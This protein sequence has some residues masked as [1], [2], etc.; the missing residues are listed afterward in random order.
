MSKDS[1]RRSDKAPTTSTKNESGK[2]SMAFSKSDGTWKRV[3]THG[4]GAHGHGHGHG[5][6]VPKSGLKTHRPV[7]AQSV[8]EAVKDLVKKRALRDLADLDYRRKLKLTIEVGIPQNMVAA[9][10]HVA[11]PTIS[12]AF[13]S[14]QDLAE[15]LEGFAGATPLE[16]CQRYAADLISR[17]VLIEQLSRFPYT[18]ADQTDGYDG[19]LVDQPGSWSEL[20]LAEARGLIDSDVYEEVFAA[21]YPDQPAE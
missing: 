17:D 13:K 16:I 9:A 4:K 21:R 20:E 3:T 14:A 15:P 7:D 1:D 5:K 12:K 10:L 2:Y 19:L 8:V 11:Q 6:H 18:E